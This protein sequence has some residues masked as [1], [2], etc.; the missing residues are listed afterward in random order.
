MNK[1]CY[2]IYDTGIQYTNNTERNPGGLWRGHKFR[3]YGTQHHI[4]NMLRDEGFQI[5]KD[6]KVHRIIRSNYFIGKRGDLEFYAEQFP[7]GFKIEFFQNI[8]F[9]NP[10]GGRYDFRKFQKMPFLIRL[11][12]IKYMNKI[13]YLLNILEDLEDESCKYYKLAEDKIKAAYVR[14]WHHE[15]K[16]MNFNLSD[17]DG[18]TQESYNGRDRDK[19]TLHNGDIKYFRHWDGRI[20]RGKVYHNINNMWWVILNKY[21]RTN[22][23]SFELFDLTPDDYLGRKKRERLPEDYQKRREAISGTKTKELVN[24]LKRRGIAVKIERK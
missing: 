1:D 4:F 17:T 13:V 5:S 20:Y 19:K 16:D 10:C 18:Q 15:Q 24:E 3:H 22:I 9:E 11:Q 21:E 23:A 14:E 6:S 8:N 12:Y 2:R 7:N